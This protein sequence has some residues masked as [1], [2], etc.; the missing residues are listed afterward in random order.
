MP[1]SVNPGVPPSV[2]PGGPP[3]NPGGPLFGID[4]RTF[5]VSFIS[6]AARSLPHAFRDLFFD[7]LIFLEFLCPRPV[8]IFEKAY[9]TGGNGRNYRKNR[10]RGKGKGIY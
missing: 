9:K 3:V 1:P 6:D 10:R 7:F 5:A 4:F 8:R 2:N